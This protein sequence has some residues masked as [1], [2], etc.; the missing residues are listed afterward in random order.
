MWEH[1]D[2]HG[3]GGMITALMWV[4]LMVGLVM[5]LIKYRNSGDVRE[6]TALDILKERYARGEIGR[7]EFEQKR[8]DLEG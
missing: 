8:L 6:K 1:F 4:L 7:E 3:W 5:L 2:N